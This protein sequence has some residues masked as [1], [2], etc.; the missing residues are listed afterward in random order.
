MLKCSAPFVDYRKSALQESFTKKR[1]QEEAE[2][3]FHGVGQVKSRF[4][5]LIEQGVLSHMRL[6]TGNSLTNRS[7][8]FIR[9]SEINATKV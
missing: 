9:K 8:L 1:L 5:H 6:T 3:A 2:V 4:L 7:K